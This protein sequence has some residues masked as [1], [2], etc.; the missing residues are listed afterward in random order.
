MLPA[1]KHHA[2]PC[3]VQSNWTT[4]ESRM[5][6]LLLSVTH[7]CTD[8]L[9]AGQ[10]SSQVVWVNTTTLHKPFWFQPLFALSLSIFDICCLQCVK[11]SKQK[12]S[13]Y[14]Q[15]NPLLASYQNICLTYAMRIFTAVA[16]RDL[17]IDRTYRNRFLCS[18]D[19][20]LC[21]QLVPIDRWQI[22]FNY[23]RKLK[24]SGNQ[25]RTQEFF[26]GRGRGVQ[27]IQLWTEDRENGDLGA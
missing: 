6:H 9:I 14:Y 10:L 2:L 3:S 22:I 25:R 11:Y 13:L 12:K 5:G 16:N 27:Q 26:R 15:V 8:R 24:D 19:I 18:W 7:R 21:R 20:E 1:S 23:N 17:C 4:E